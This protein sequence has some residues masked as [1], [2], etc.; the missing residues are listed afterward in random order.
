MIGKERFWNVEE[1]VLSVFF[2]QDEKSSVQQVRIPVIEY[3]TKNKYTFPA[4]GVWQVNGNYDCIGAHRTQ[5]SMK[6]AFGIC[7]PILFLGPC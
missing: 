4:K 1:L 2:L 7:Q 5:Y 3:K 6:F